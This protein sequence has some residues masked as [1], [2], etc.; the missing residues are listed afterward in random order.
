MR[1]AR[2]RETATKPRG[3]GS[4]RD[5][6]GERPPP[7]PRRLSRAK[8]QEQS[9]FIFPFS[10]FLFFFP[11]LSSQPANLG[12]GGEEEEGRMMVLDFFF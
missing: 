11:P 2:G 12:G 10:F 3:A 4:E 8:M 5:A 9:D 6:R 1:G 7:R